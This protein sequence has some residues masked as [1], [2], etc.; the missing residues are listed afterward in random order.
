MGN[1]FTS[2]RFSQGTVDSMFYRSRRLRGDDEKV[3]QYLWAHPDPEEGEVFMWGG[4][5]FSGSH[6]ILVKSETMLEEGE[7]LWIDGD[8]YVVSSD[9]YD[10]GVGIKAYV[11]SLSMR[12]FLA[13]PQP[14]LEVLSNDRT[15][16]RFTWEPS[17]GATT[18]GVDWWQ[19][20]R[21]APP[22]E[23]PNTNE[24]AFGHGL[25]FDRDNLRADRTYYFYARASFGGGPISDYSEAIKYEI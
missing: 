11:L 3:A 25:S 23:D 24:Y 10:V 5:R 6:A 8:G 20:D 4:Y 21:G 19:L 16:I 7:T 9:A 12:N 14:K 2:G 17:R 13:A 15:R 1:P 18:Y 22:P